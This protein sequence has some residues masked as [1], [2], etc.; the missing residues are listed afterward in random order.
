LGQG[1]HHRCLSISCLVCG[2]PIGSHQKLH[3]HRSG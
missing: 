1:L 2:L 3:G